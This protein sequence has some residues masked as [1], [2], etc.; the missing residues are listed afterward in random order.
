VT[1]PAKGARRTLAEMLEE[2]PRLEIDATHPA[3]V[4][5]RAAHHKGL[6]PE[7]RIRLEDIRAHRALAKRLG[8]LACPVC[9][10]AIYSAA[11]VHPQCAVFQEESSPPR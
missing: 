1:H 4:A 8:R 2:P 11:G 6:S 3:K 10:H 7:A 9:G 5:R